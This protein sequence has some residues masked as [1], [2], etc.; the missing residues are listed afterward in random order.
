MSVF[1]AELGATVVGAPTGQ[2]TKF[3]CPRGM[4]IDIVLPNSQI[5]VQVSGTWHEVE[6][7]VEPV[8]DDEGKLYEWENTVLPDVFVEQDIEDLRL[9]KDSLMEWVWRRWL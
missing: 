8:Y 7:L 1:K 4:N 5:T 6:G 3:F 2:F 9:G